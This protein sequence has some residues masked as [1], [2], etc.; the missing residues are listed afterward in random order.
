[1]RFKTKKTSSFKWCKSRSPSY[2]RLEVIAD[3]RQPSSFAP[4]CVRYR[5]RK[6]ETIILEL[7]LSLFS[8]IGA[9]VH[10]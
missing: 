1:M 2:S 3:Q 9:L 10:G 8:S 6:I 4:L 7:I 5:E